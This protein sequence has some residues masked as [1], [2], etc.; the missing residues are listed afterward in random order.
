MPR[1]ISATCTVSSVGDGA[2]CSASCSTRS[3]YG[4]AASYLAASNSRRKPL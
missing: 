3:A 1:F 4:S 2:A